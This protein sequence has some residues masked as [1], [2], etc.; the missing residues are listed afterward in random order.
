MPEGLDESLM[1]SAQMSVPGPSPKSLKAMASRTAFS[2][3]V[4]MVGIQ[5]ASPVSNLMILH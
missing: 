4:I 3:V 2:L 1:Q 5:W